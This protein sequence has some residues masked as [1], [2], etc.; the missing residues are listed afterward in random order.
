MRHGLPA[1]H[2]PRDAGWPTTSR[3]P[4]LSEDPACA[5]PCSDGPIASRLSADVSEPDPAILPGMDVF[6]AA[7]QTVT[8]I[9]AV[10]AVIVSLQARRDARIAQAMTA[11]QAKLDRALAGPLPVITLVHE[12]G[13][14]GS[15][16]NVRVQNR[17][18]S[19]ITMS[20]GGLAFELQDGGLRHIVIAYNQEVRV[21]PEG[22]PR[23]YTITAP[24][25]QNV[26]QD[27]A[28]NSAIRPF[29]I[30]GTS[31]IYGEPPLPRPVIEAA[32]ADAPPAPDQTFHVLD[33][34]DDHLRERDLVPDASSGTDALTHEL[35]DGLYRRF[36][37]VE[38]PDE[39]TR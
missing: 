4:T 21:D 27:A 35:T 18:R 38:W 11:E 32:V 17:G 33:A 28:L 7:L 2:Q 3:W 39:P 22:A 15:V 30:C 37:T 5:T 16:I 8:T 34:H 36:L 31:T 6:N 10:L 29:V 1:K 20:G 25:L 12:R 14:H 19:A 24:I 23:G 9:M 13:E 26:L